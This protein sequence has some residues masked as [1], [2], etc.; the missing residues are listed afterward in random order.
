MKMRRV[1]FIVIA[2]AVCLGMTGVNAL[3]EAQVDVSSL[4]KARDVESSY[5][6]SEATLIDLDTRNGEVLINAKGDYVLSGSLRGQILIEAPEEDK[7]R[8]ILN[9]V[10]IVSDL[11]PAIYEKRADKLIITLAEGS[12]NELTAG[13]A[14][15]DDDDTIGA[16][17][18][19]EDD[20]SVNGAG[21]L[22]A[23]SAAKHGIQSKADLIIADGVISVE[24]A[25]D[26]I[27]GR[28]SVLVLGGSIR[29]KA[30]GDGIT[31]TREDK[32]G[33]GWVLLDG[34]SFDITTGDG[35]GAVRASANSQMGRGGWVGRGYPAQ[36]QADSGV[37]QKAIKAAA[38]LTVQGGSYTIDSADDALHAVNVAVSGGEFAIRTGDDGVHADETA[39]ISGGVLF[40]TQCYEGVEGTDV[41][42]TGGTISVI[43][44]DDAINAAGGGDESGMM[45]GW[46]MRGGMSAASGSLTIS[47]GTVVANASG[48]GL[49]SNGNISITGGLVCVWAQTNGGEGTIDFNGTGSI[50][51]GTLIVATN[52]GSMFG[53]GALS[54]QSMMTVSL[55]K[56]Y[57]AGAEVVLRDASDSAL[58]AFTPEGAYSVLMISSDRLGDGDAFSV[59]CGG[60]EAYSGSM[61]NNSGTA[62]GWGGPQGGWGGPRGGWG[63][64]QGGRRR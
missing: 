50:S 17:L 45:G 31:A 19:A 1:I 62:D 20:L 37:S 39:R 25:S 38:T 3:A 40:I 26:G 33:K 6:E 55:T 58:A 49:D 35:A 30:D 61:T 51:G 53:G 47:G 13:A 36:T 46:G 21:E 34:G 64:Q 48:D 15:T 57:S 2:L 54:G 11:G 14:I 44:S 32:D 27:R 59:T 63:S 60:A 18:Y 10:S 8:L 7:V 9:G 41:V 24:A 52:Q 22:R 12:V 28:N 29:I 43:A 56:A 23:V 16:A 4:Y 42:I 5:D